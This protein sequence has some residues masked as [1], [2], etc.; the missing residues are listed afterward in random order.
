MAKTNPRT[1]EEHQADLAYD[2]ARTTTERAN[3]ALEKARAD[4]EGLKGQSATLAIEAFLEATPGAATESYRQ[5]EVRIAELSR[6]VERLTQAAT[7]AATREEKARVDLM[8][9]RHEGLVLKIDKKCQ[10]MAKFAEDA[11]RAIELARVAQRRM[12]ELATEIRGLSPVNLPLFGDFPLTDQGVQ[13]AIAYE[14]W[15][16]DAADGGI[17]D[18]ATTLP[19]G[20]TADGLLTGRRPAPGKPLASLLPALPDRVREMSL[21]IADALRGKRPEFAAPS[22]FSGSPALVARDRKTLTKLQK[23]KPAN[24]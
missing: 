5:L 4:L 16:Q 12:R 13:N 3:A 21:L 6:L 19:G 23:E 7:E 14:A 24:A 18:P 15:R 20:K 1:P 2:Q 10:Q 22:L 11:V 9:Q 17:L 8:A